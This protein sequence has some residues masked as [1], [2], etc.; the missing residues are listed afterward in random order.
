VARGSE[1]VRLGFVPWDTVEGQALDPPIRPLVGALNR[2]GWVHTVFS[3]AGHP[4]E[5]DS[6]PRGRRQAHVDVL[7]ADPARWRAYVGRVRGAAA[8]AVRALG[9]SSGAGGAGGAGGRAG[10][11]VT[12]RVAEGSLGA[13]PEWLRA[14]VRGEDVSGR[15][16][17]GPPLWQ[18][19]LPDALTAAPGPDGRRWRYRRLVLEPVP[20]DLAPDRCRGVLDAALGAAVGVL[21]GQAPGPAGA[22]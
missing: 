14:A 22:P 18:Q 5:P 20:Y 12:V 10:G 13:P 1:S 3:C 9:V 19:L 6:G 8:A 4:E 11:E 7:V 16:R 2:A 21:G 15:D 17:R